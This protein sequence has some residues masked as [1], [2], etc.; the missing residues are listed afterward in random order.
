[1]PISALLSFSQDVCTLFIAI[2]SIVTRIVTLDVAWGGA[3]MI[4]PY[5]LRYGKS[6]FAVEL[7]CG[8]YRFSEMYGEQQRAVS[9]KIIHD[10]II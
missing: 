3:R 7:D 1:M 6:K 2:R 10:G 8:G 4:R 5:F 9:Y